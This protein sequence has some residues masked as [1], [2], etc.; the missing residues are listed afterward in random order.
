MNKPRLASDNIN[1]PREMLWKAA[2]MQNVTQELKARGSG[3]KRMKCLVMDDME[4]FAFYFTSETAHY[5][6]C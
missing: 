1:N 6:T 4:K 3:M 2:Q 5:H